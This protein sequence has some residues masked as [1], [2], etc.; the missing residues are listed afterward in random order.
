M[1]KAAAVA[2][3]PCSGVVGLGCAPALASAHVI[4]ARTAIYACAV[5]TAA[6][7]SFAD[8]SVLAPRTASDIPAAMLVKSISVWRMQPYHRQTSAH[9]GVPF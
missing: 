1:L 2:V 8:A 7:D 6:A 5:C 4:A 9:R 3:H